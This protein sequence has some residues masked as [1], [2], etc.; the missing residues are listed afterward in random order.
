MLY[1]KIEKKFV[2]AFYLDKKSF[3]LKVDMCSDENRYI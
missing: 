1:A 2:G 3:Q